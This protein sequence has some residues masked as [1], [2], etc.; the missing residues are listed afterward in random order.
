MDL[1][2]FPD[3]GF[4]VLDRN[5]YNYHKKIMHYSDELDSIL[6]NEL[7]Y[8]IDKKRKEDGPFKAGIV[9]QYYDLYEKIKKN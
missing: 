3:G 2:V 7:S 8:L 6:K 5:E 4:R 1:R 9:K